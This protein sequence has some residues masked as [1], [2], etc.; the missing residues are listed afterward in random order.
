MIELIDDSPPLDYWHL[1]PLC[2][3]MVQHVC[4]GESAAEELE[5]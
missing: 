5:M 4:E 1:Y 2:L 3:S